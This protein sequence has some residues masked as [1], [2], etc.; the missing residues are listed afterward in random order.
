MKRRSS[1]FVGW[2]S[3]AI[4]L[5]VSLDGFGAHHF[6]NKYS[7]V[8]LTQD[9]GILNE[10]DLAA[11]T[12]NNNPPLFSEKNPKNYNY[13]QCF[14]RDH[15]SITLID[16]GFS[17]EEIGNTENYGDLF[18]KA[19]SEN[20]ILHEY[21]M[22]RLQEVS[23]QQKIF[24][25][26]QKL[27]KGEKYVCLAGLSGDF[28]KSMKDNKEYVTYFWTFDKI[29]TKKGCDSFFLNQCNPSHSKT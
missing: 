29:K 12:W 7:H 5:C 1:F 8:L 15:V 17:A 16:K 13:W 27:M 18:I 24:M 9:Y 6:K 19:W 21:S 25:Q 28:E 22:R 4:M 11:Y 3:F 10:N 20:G 23:E 26:W 2:M 14:P